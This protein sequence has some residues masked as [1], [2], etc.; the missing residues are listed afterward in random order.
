M[1]ETSVNELLEDFRKT[2]VIPKKWDK[3]EPDKV[4]KLIGFQSAFIDENNR[5]DCIISTSEEVISALNDPLPSELSLKNHTGTSTKP[6]IGLYFEY[7]TKNNL[8]LNWMPLD[9]LPV[10]RN[11][12]NL[13]PQDFIEY[14]SYRPS[15]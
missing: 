4:T 8:T 11:N 13:I 5:N 14:N 6:R 7:T 9:Y 1:R 12:L 10:D 15:F 3:G 2:I